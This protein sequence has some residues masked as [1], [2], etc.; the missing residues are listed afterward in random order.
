[1]TEISKPVER[2]NLSPAREAQIVEELAQHLEDRCKDL[3]AS[4]IPAAS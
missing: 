4:P 1:M 3:L 2:L